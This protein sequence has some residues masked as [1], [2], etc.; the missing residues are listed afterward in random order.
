MALPVGIGCLLACV[1][2]GC[3]AQ[4]W[5]PWKFAVRGDCYCHCYC[6]C[7]YL[8]A[9]HIQ[10][11]RALMRRED[12][13]VLY[14]VVGWLG[15]GSRVGAEEEEEGRRSSYGWLPGTEAALDFQG[16]T[17]GTGERNGARGTDTFVWMDTRMDAKGRFPDVPGDR[18][19]GV[20]RVGIS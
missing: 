16:Q 13:G 5:E 1:P 2:L 12:A 17:L 15:A 10:F 8:R 6:L 18:S 3:S 7:C 20:L 4:C 9:D 14:G 19:Q 11:L